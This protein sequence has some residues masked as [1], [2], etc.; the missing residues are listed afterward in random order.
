[1][2]YCNILHLT[3]MT[4]D[5]K[6]LLLT[7]WLRTCTAYHLTNMSKEEVRGMEIVVFYKQSILGNTFGWD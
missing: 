7:R 5:E 4:A 1:M 2:V 6:R 3:M